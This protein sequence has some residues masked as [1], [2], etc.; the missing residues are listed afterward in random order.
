[1][2]RTGQLVLDYPRRDQTISFLIAL[3]VHLSTLAVGGVLFVKPVQFGVETGVSGIEVHL[4]AVPQEPVQ[5][6]PKEKIEIVKQEIENAVPLPEEIPVPEI[7]EAIQIPQVVQPVSIPVKEP[8]K[9][10]QPVEKIKKIQSPAN[11]GKDE[12]TLTSTGGALTEAKPNYLQNPAP[13][14]PSKARRLGQEG[15]VVL[16]VDVDRQGNP[17]RVKVKLSSDYS[18]LDKSALKAVRR[19]KFSP[20]RIGILAVD[21]NVEVPIRFRLESNNK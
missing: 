20:A 13:V 6:V 7:K 14:Y 8:V 10:V 5:Q 19:W 21:S 3:G 11:T 18:L 4:V 2:N 12:M 1:M 16:S 17:F 9:E 15:L